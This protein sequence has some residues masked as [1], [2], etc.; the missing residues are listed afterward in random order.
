MISER[1]RP[2]NDD[3][4]AR[5]RLILR[6]PPSFFGER[7]RVST[8]V[9]GLLAGSL[10]GAI[11][12]ALLT[13]ISG[14]WAAATLAACGL[15][16]VGG[17]HG[18]YLRSLSRGREAR[19]PFR[20]DLDGA[21][22]RE[23]ECR[24]SSAAVVEECEDEGISVLL[25]VEQAAV[26]FL[27]GQYLYDPVDDGQFPCTHFALVRAPLSGEILDLRLLGEPLEPS[28]RTAADALI[29]FHQD[30]AILEGRVHDYLA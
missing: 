8:W 25:Q 11:P 22:V 9:G 30:G 26:L 7:R 4:A 6:N 13:G 24:P 21:V 14:Q 12:A 5:L 29:G 2:M 10:G 1:D 20:L 16:G 28:H 27:Q 17:A 15:L 3:E 18:L 23:L 19:Q